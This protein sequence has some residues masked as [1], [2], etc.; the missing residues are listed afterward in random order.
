MLLATTMNAPR[1]KAKSSESL[2]HI[3]ASK[4]GTA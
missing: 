4:I 2:I 1:Q 3:P